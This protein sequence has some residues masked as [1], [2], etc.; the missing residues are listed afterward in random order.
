MVF[1]IFGFLVSRIFG[2][3]DFWFSGFL[4]FW[5]LGFLVF[6]FSRFRFFDFLRQFFDDPNQFFED[7][8][9]FFSE[10]NQKRILD[11]ENVHARG[12]SKNGVPIVLVRNP[13]RKNWMTV[14]GSRLCGSSLGAKYVIKSDLNKNWIWPPKNWFGSPKNWFEKPENQKMKNLKS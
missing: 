1:W 12:A 10:P 4:D 13:I 7:P 8:N 6:W 14:F 5:I 2:F 11:H 3:L 9:Q